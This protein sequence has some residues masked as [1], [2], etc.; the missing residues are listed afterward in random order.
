M[1]YAATG[2]HAAPFLL[3][4]AAMLLGAVAAWPRGGPARTS[5]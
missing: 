4:G 1:R 5:R 3:G 2:G